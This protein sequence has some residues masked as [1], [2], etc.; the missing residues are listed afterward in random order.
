[1]LQR[2]VK[3]KYHYLFGDQFLVAPI[4]KDQ[5]ANTVTLPE[6]NWRYFFNDQEVIRGPVTFEREFPLDEY[7]V[8]I[9]EGAI[10]PM[11]IK[12]DYTGI[13]SKDSEGYLT[14]LVYPEGKSLFTVQ[15]PDKSGNTMIS[16]NDGAEKTI[17]SLT[18]VQKPHILNIRMPA[19]PQKVELDGRLLSD[20]LNYQFNKKQNKLV[21]RTDQYSIGNYVIYK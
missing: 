3:G 11:D 14:L 20:S 1:L 4:Y 19:A 12:R 15:H 21:I 8:Y 9:R 7:P 2:P 16:V 17:V 5:L 10:V 6:G 13:G 18:G